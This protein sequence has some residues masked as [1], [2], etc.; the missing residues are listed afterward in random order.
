MLGGVVQS[1]HDDV[2]LLR[3]GD[4]LDQLVHL[5]PHLG[6]SVEVGGGNGGLAGRSEI[7]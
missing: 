7:I 4:G 5:V 3:E 2:V 6:G 1:L